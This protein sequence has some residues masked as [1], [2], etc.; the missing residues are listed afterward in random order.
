MSDLLLTCDTPCTFHLDAEYQDR[1]DYKT[2]L[3]TI[4]FILRVVSKFLNLQTEGR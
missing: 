2:T 1:N 3:K 4:H